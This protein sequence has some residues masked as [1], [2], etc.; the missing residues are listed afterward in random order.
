MHRRSVEV[1][2]GF[3]V[4][5][6]IGTVGYALFLAGVALLVSHFLVR[7][8]HKLLAILIAVPLI[9]TMFGNSVWRK[10]AVINRTKITYGDDATKLVFHRGRYFV[11][12]EDAV[13]LRAIDNVKLNRSLLGKVFG[14]CDLSLETRS[15]GYEI[16]YV[17]SKQAE[18]FR[19][20][21]LDMLR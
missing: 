4:W 18:I 15:E 12:D 9:A 6:W 10:L 21:F 3:S 16:P 14:W 17:S 19:K 7:P 1:S 2:P 8:E 11:K 13:P 20:E 5:Y